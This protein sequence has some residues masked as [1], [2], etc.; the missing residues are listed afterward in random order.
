L[1]A[2]KSVR[3]TLFSSYLLLILIFIP[4]LTVFSYFYTANALKRQAIGALEDLSATVVGALDGELFKMNAVS[5]NIGSSELVRELLQEHAALRRRAT[6]RGSTSTPRA[7]RRSCR[8]S[9][10]PTSRCPRSTSTT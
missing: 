10:G 5:V 8:P 4:L 1:Q 6:A 7:W 9:S 2:V 3:A